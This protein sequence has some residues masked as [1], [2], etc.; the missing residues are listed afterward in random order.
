M[1]IPVYI[2]LLITIFGT[3]TLTFF[4]V[5][6]DQ[7]ID[8]E[9]KSRKVIKYVPV[10]VTE[11]VARFP[12]VPK[13]PTLDQSVVR[14]PDVLNLAKQLNLVK[15]LA[16]EEDDER[17]E[18]I[19]TAIRTSL[20]DQYDSFLAQNE[21]QI[22]QLQERL[23]KLKDQ[24]YRRRQAKAKM[25]DLEFER[26]VNESEG[27]VWPEPRSRSNLDRRRKGLGDRLAIPNSWRRADDE[28]SSVDPF[29]TMK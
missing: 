13:V 10:E 16:G 9:P 18:E 20:E 17:K 14:Q 22:E 23:D 29:G 19:E 15:Q 24:L 12:A 4:S 21:K 28:P 7:A 27:L 5:Y 11:E 26:I 8:S 2:S 1:K 6:Q 25:V 3:S